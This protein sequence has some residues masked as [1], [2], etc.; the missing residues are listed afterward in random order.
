M[1]NFTIDVTS[2]EMKLVMSNDLYVKEFCEFCIALANDN[3]EQIKND[4]K[5]KCKL[6]KNSLKEICLHSHR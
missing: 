6:Y 2:E 4:K 5:L 3:K 1:N